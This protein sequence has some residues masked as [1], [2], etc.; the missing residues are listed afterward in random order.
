MNQGIKLFQCGGYDT[1]PIWIFVPSHW[2]WHVPV[3]TLNIN[4]EVNPQKKTK[5]DRPLPEEYN[6]KI[7]GYVTD[8]EVKY[9]MI[10]WSRFW[11]HMFIQESEGY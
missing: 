6:G 2:L 3:F 8:L 10:P 1:L 7:I 11:I 5:S 9:Q 4:N